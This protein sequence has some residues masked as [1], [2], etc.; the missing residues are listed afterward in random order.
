MSARERSD[1]AL[2]EAELAPGACAEGTLRE[3]SARY[4]R[5]VKGRLANNLIIMHISDY[6]RFVNV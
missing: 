4:E 5:V 1:R 3:M 2:R 6:N